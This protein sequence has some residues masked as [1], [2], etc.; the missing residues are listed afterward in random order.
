MTPAQVG[1]YS[2]V[3]PAIATLLGWWL[4]DEHLTAAQLAGMVVILA[5]V[6][7]VSWPSEDPQP[8]PTG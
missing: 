4:L 7:L 2:Y 8:E 1:T 6:V 3:N 5:G